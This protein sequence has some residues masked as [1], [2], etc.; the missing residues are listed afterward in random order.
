MQSLDKIITHSG[1][2]HRD[3]FLACSIL[4]ASYNVSE[5]ERKTE[6][7]ESEL[8]NSTIAVVD[9]GGSFDLELNNFD[10]H[11]DEN[12]PCS[13][14]LVAT[15]VFGRS[16]LS[17]VFVWWENVNVQDTEGFP[18]LARNYGLEPKQLQELMDPIGALLLKAFEEQSYFT[19]E[20][21]L[22][23]AM[24]AIGNNLIDAVNKFEKHLSAMRIDEYEGIKVAFTTLKSNIARFSFARKNG[25]KIIVAPNERGKGFT[26]TRVDDAEG[27]DFRWCQG[28]ENIT[29]IHPNGFMCVVETDEPWNWGPYVRKATI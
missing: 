2:A 16:D 27:I 26:L 17:D 22:Y 14:H 29:F 6:V 10:H 23:W 21:W 19:K 12:L 20:H 25:L 8:A 24:K 9:V 13:L 18:T 15:A 11:H 4:L 3:E 1:T 5:I 28:M 7:S